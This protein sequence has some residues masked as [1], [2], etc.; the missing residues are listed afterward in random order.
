MLRLAACFICDAG[1]MLDATVHDAVLVEADDSGIDGAVEGA[2]KAMDRASELVLH[3][4]RLRTD[5]E[6]IH[7]PERYRDDRGAAFF[8]E[9]MSRLQEYTSVNTC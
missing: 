6:V 4:F 1:L 8:D 9:L 2:R 3:G 5:F 7:W